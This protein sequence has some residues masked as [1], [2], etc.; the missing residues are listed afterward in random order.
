MGYSV[1]K[2]HIELSDEEIER[3]ASIYH[4]WKYDMNYR[5]V[6][7]FCKSVSTQQVLSY[8]G[9]LTPSHFIDPIEDSVEEK[10]FSQ[11]VGYI[12]N[13]LHVWHEELKEKEMLLVSAEIFKHWFIDFDFPN[14]LGKPY[15]TSGG[16]MTPS[17]FG[18]IPKGWKIE[19]ITQV[20]EV[21]DCLHAPKPE[22]VDDGPILLQVYNIGQDG[23]IDLTERY[24]V[25]PA[26]YQYWI[27]N[28]EVAENDCV[29]SN[30]GRVGAVARIPSY[31]KAGIGRNMTAIRAKKIPPSYL[32][33]YL[34][35]KYGKKEIQANT[36]E[37]T[38]LNSLNV[39]GIK[40]IRI[41]LPD[42]NVMDKFERLNSW[43]EKGIDTC[44]K[45]TLDFYYTNSPK[46]LS[47]EICHQFENIKN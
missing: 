46:L 25:S 18:E 13:K 44:H 4:S 31:F 5:D 47:G 42:Q 17:D 19:L 36:D 40:K 7:G 8:G 1:D 29:I 23:T 15:K 43:L 28:I 37:G 16:E 35:S 6:P 33:G 11:K 24:C 38:I 39:R 21:I 12:N 14:N 3:I 9:V 22:Q 45:N 34:L 27:K 20:A 32:I 26:D 10:S 41:L 2:T 30:V